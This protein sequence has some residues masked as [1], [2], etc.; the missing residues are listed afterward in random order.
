MR[1]EKTVIQVLKG[2]IQ[3]FGG[4]TLSPEGQLK[5][6]EI[7]ENRV[8]IGRKTPPHNSI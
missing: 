4:F 6:I 1:D 5:P 7:S 2:V 8:L 3:N